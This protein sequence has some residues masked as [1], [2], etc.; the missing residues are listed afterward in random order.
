MASPFV[1]V[2]LLKESMRNWFFSEYFKFLVKL[3]KWWVLQR[4]VAFDCENIKK[5]WII[6]K[7]HNV[8]KGRKLW[9]FLEIK[10]K[11]QKNNS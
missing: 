8:S 11:K 9:F 2:D 5:K 6:S 7:K 10:Y 1:H 3:T 4:V